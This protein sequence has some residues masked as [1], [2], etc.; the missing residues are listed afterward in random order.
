MPH[1]QAHSDTNDHQD[2]HGL[3]FAHDLPR[4]MGRRKMLGLMAGLG[5]GTAAAGPAFALD[6]CLPMPPETAGPFPAN[7]TRT[8]GGL[9]YNALDQAGVI[10][11]DMRTSFGGMT[12]IAEGVP[13]EM[14]LELVSAGADCAPLGGYA[15]YLWHCDAIGR[16]SM[17]DM[18]DN[19]LRAVGV[20]G[21]DGKLSFTT[22]FPGCYPGRWPHVHFEVFE[23]PL[24]AVS[25]A[26]PVLTSQWAFT[27][28][29]S[30]DVYAADDRYTQSAKNLSRLSM[31][32]DS[33]FRDNNDAQMKAQTMQTTGSP[34]NGFQGQLKIAIAL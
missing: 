30:Q 22:V 27:E 19:Y 6:Q 11:S 14:D 2:D 24:A 34:Q 7:G 10:R 12:S 17:Y 1:D 18:D 20:A 32:R 26:K 16:Y 15:I 23:T 8:R 3:G 21:A 29:H 9:A 28:K 31:R 13:L 4:M 5:L 25:G 33:I